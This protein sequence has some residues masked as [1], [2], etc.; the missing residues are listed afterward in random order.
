MVLDFTVFSWS[1]KMLRLL[2]D[3]GKKVGRDNVGKVMEADLIPL[4]EASDQQRYKNCH[5]IEGRFQRIRKGKTKLK[6]SSKSTLRSF[7][8]L[9]P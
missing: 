6:T 1:Q 8:S 7:N 3:H 9:Y 2:Q 4:E 5:Q